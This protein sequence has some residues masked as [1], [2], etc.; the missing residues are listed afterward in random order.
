MKALRNLTQA[1]V[2]VKVS[3]KNGN[4]TAIITNKGDVPALML[5]VK[6]VDSKSGDLIL[7]VWYS[8]NYIFLMG[9]E[10]RTIS[11]KVRDEDCQG[12][13]IIKVEGF[14]YKR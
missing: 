14:T 7:P 9:G 3:G 13:P 11:I 10:S 12:K 5:R 2:E 1:D 6:A 4:Y 8:E